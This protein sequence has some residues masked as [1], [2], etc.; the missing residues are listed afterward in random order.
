MSIESVEKV[1]AAELAAAGVRKKAEEDA[2][3]IIQNAKK[4]ANDIIEKADI[5][6]DIKYREVIARAEEKAEAIYKGKIEEEQ[7]SCSKI[8][9]EGR[10]RI[11]EAIEA[12]VRK[13]VKS[14]GNS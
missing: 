9:A 10:E 3:A 8:K 1:R 6:A 14:D 7:I 5:T 4:E 11:G 2:A 13:V 12:I